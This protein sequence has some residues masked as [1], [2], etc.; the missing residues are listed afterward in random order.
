[1]MVNPFVRLVSAQ[2]WL[3]YYSLSVSKFGLLYFNYFLA[4]APNH[5][6]RNISIKVVGVARDPNPN[7]SNS[8]HTHKSRMLG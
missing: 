3:L 4:T 7:I 6:G 1:M 8:R 2:C 5:R